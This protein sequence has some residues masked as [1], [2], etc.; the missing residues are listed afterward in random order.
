[1]NMLFHS[2]ETELKLFKKVNVITKVVTI[3]SAAA[4]RVYTCH[5]KP[6][7]HNFHKTFK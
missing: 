5:N 6:Y 2:I 7:A 3:K 4:K 1:M